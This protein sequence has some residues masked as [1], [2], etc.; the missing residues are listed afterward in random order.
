MRSAAA[1]Q[2]RA[3]PRVDAAARAE[4][5]DRRPAVRRAAAVGVDRSRR[6]AA[7]GDE[8]PPGGVGRADHHLRAGR[9]R[10]VRDRGCVGRTSDTRHRAR[11]HGVRPARGQR[12]EHV[13]PHRLP[14]HLPTVRRRQG[15][16]RRVTPV[17]HVPLPRRRVAVRVRADAVVLL[18][19]ARSARPDGHHVDPRGRRRVRQVRHA[20][21]AG[22]RQRAVRRT[23]GGDG[24]R[25][26][27]GALR[28]D[29]GALRAGADARGVGGE[30]DGRRQRPAAPGARH[31]RH[32]RPRVARGAVA[33]AGFTWCR[34][35]ASEP[36]VATSRRAGVRPLPLDG[37]LVVDATKFLAGPFGCLVLQ[38]LGARVVKVDP[39]GGEEFR[40]VAA[41][42]YSRAEPRQGPGLSSTS[43]TPAGR[44]A[45]TALVHR[46]D[47]LVENMARQVASELE[48]RPRRPARRQPG[49]V[50]S[51]ID[52]W[53]KG[54]SPTRPAST[55]CSRRGAGSWSRRAAPTTR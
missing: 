49:L 22:D 1:R 2:P 18:Q 15:R 20:A 40:A 7:G 30:R 34:R 42:S 3:G 27:V 46:A 23:D 38:D 33:H 50:H 11:V 4:R 39:P 26:V 44:D 5:G 17:P 52:G 53:G 16:H 43:R 48:P 14:R 45:F 10:G 8:R 13:D 51:H 9:A 37:M 21:G 35:T 36:S 31:G 6:A 25:P 29:R 55:R 19:A 47:A 24:L 28:R 41:A 32:R 12:D 54:P